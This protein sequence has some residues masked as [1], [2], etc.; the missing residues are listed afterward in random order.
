MKTAS[1]AE[2]FPELIHHTHCKLKL[3]LAVRSEDK[4]TQI[5][6]LVL[7]ADWINDPGIHALIIMIQHLFFIFESVSK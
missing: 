2:S 1:L 7:M 4:H 3:C 6:E 5:K